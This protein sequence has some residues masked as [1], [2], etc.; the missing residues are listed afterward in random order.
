M[1]A[2]KPSGWEGGGH[3]GIRAMASAGVQARASELPGSA[4]GRF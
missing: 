2:R 3:R 1:P 4:T